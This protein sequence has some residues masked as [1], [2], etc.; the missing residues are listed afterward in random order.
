MHVASFQAAARSLGGQALLRAWGR[1][2]EG[3]EEVEESLHA[4]TAPG[5]EDDTDD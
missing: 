5:G 3:N 1:D 2:A 4:L